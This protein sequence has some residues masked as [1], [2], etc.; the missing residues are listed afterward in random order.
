MMTPSLLSERSGKGDTCTERALLRSERMAL[1]T[2]A[3]LAAQMLA[4]QP[5]QETRAQPSES[6]LAREVENPVSKLSSFPVRYQNDFGIGPQNLERS[7]LS[8]RPTLAFPVTRDMSIVSRTTVPIVAQPDVVNRRYTSG[9]GDTVESLFFVPRPSSDVIWGVGP[10][11]SF[12]TAVPGVLGSG[13]VA[14][15]PAAAALMQ[16][17]L[18]TLGVLGVQ[19]WSVAGE[20]SRPDISRLSVQCIGALHLPRGWYVHTAP[21]VSANWNASSFRNMWTIPVGGGGGKVLHLGELPINVSVTAYW[22]VVRPQTL[23]A[24]SGNVQAQVALLLPGW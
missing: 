24:P 19:V 6:E 18:L 21:V 17:G 3:V 23:V 1:A 10:S 16:S 2:A 22:N 11:V 5:G 13:R 8:L 7:T 12:P 4:A 14:V 9:L 20:T 15:G